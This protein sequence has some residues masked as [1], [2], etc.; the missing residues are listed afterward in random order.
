MF[1]KKS[2]L[3]VFEEILLKNCLEHGKVLKDKTKV[4]VRDK[5]S[6]PQ[7]ARCPYASGALI[8]I[9]FHPQTAEKMA[10]PCMARLDLVNC[11][12]SCIRSVKLVQNS[13]KLSEE[14]AKVAQGSGKVVK[15]A[16]MSAVHS[17]VCIQ[18]LRCNAF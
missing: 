2:I 17:I 16:K 13:A 6:N 15:N 1:T 4:S 8:R 3:A 12:K 18:H 14:S 5:T 9:Y 10:P 7:Q 11:R